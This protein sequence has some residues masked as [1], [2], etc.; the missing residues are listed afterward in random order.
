MN[1]EPLSIQPIP[2][3]GSKRALAPR[4]CSLFP[5]EVTT[6]YEP[7]AGSAAVTLFAAT[8]DLAERFVIGDIYAPLVDLWALIVDD[9]GALSDR[10]A[11]VWHAQFARG[12]SHFNDV[13]AEFNE[14]NDPVLLLYL[15][16]RCVKNAVRFNRHGQFT[17]SV[18]KRRNGMKPDRVTRT[19][20]A[21]S[22]LLKG[23]VRLF[24]G[25]FRECVRDAT[26]DDLV[27]MDPP[28]QGTT[29]GTDKRYAEGLD[30]GRLVEA[31]HGLDEGAVPYILSYDGQT[32]EK[33]YGEPLP[34]TIDADHLA[35]HAGRS[36]QAT[37]SG[38][39]AVTI[40]SLYVS[41]SLN[42]RDANIYLRRPMQERLF[43]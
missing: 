43:A 31:L 10:Y 34:G 41:R 9:P 15:I 29:Y 36:S 23:R 1:S 4:I 14:S 2:Y 21:V 39:D 28:Y 35:I 5:R 8:H 6:L 25:D 33:I 12:A 17:Q 18:D 32:G 16:A 13:R 19:A 38:R 20:H 24:R 30:R 11:A 40:E 3:Q 27:Y 26:P 42:A 22:R 7:F 37:I